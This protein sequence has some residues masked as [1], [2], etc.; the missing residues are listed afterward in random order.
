MSIESPVIIIH[1]QDQADQG[2]LFFE[3]GTDSLSRN[4]GTELPLHAAYILRRAQI[5]VKEARN[6]DFALVAVILIL[7]NLMATQGPK[8]VAVYLIS[9]KLVMF[10]MNDSVIH[11]YNHK[12]CPR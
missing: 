6:H 4:V 12:G 2:C 8:R 1:V 7:Y 11:S 5:S 9:K 3:H 10:M